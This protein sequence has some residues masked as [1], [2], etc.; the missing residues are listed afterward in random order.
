M[1]RRRRKA[2]TP[3]EYLDFLL[4]AV[5]DRMTLHAEHLADLRASA[6]SDETI[7]AQRIRTVPPWMIQKLLRRTPPKPVRHAYV[8]PYPDP[9]GGFM[10]HVRMKIFPSVE[11]TIAELGPTG[12]TRRLGVVK[13]LQ[14]PA[15]GVRIFFPVA[16][17]DAVLHSAADLHIIEG[18]KKALAVAQ[19][20]VATIGIAGCEGWHEARS[21]KLHPDLDD[22]GL[23]G[24]IVH[25]WPDSD[26]ETNPMVAYAMDRLG[27]ALKARGVKAL[28][29]IHPELA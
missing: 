27:L 12:T 22:V 26:V 18:E 3:A 23:E 13:Y 20:G 4:S 9:R 10:P 29:L 1:S 28:T 14:P 8:L 15:S 17:I 7:T 21:E 11:R 16:T 25:L 19:T 6:L 24:R 5:Y 2:A